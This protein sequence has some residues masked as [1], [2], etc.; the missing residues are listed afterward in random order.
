MKAIHHHNNLIQDLLLRVQA[1][2]L[3]VDPTVLHDRVEKAKA[4]KAAEEA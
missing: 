3:G 1:L 4:A 2:E